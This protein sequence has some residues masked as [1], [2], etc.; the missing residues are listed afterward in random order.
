MEDE[1]IAN[2][3]RFVEGIIANDIA[4][5][6]GGSAKSIGVF[7]LAGE[8]GTLDIGAVGHFQNVGHVGGCGDIENG[9]L[10]AIFD[11]VDDTANEN[12]SARGNCFAG[13]EEDFELWVAGPGFLDEANEAGD[14]VVVR[15]DE[16]ASA[17]VEP[18][19]LAEVFVE[20][21]KDVFKGTLEGVGSLLA[22]GVKVETLDSLKVVFIH[23][24]SQDA[25]AGSGSAWVVNFGAGF[26]VF[27]I[28]AQAG[29]NPTVSTEDLFAVVL[30]LGEGIKD[31][32]VGHFD[33]FTHL[34]RFVSGR[35]Y[36]NFATEVLGSEACFE[37]SAGGGAGEVI[38]KDGIDRGAREGLLSE[39]DFGAGFVLDVFQDASVVVEG[40]LVENVGRCGKTA[41]AEG[42]G[43]LWNGGG[44]FAAGWNG[45]FHDKGARC[46][47]SWIHFGI[48]N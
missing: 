5:E 31:D 27:G 7:F 39:K 45:S 24:A 34:V 11:D 9:D 8:A 32:V 2:L 4:T 17:H 21:G 22:E 28:D 25:E 12:S 1:L 16:V 40:A 33:K 42:I 44:S 46:A 14:I 13:L 15:G 6:A 26:G 35:K 36:V 37:E 20:F 38:S 3:E 10:H 41:L 18:F 29:G 19:H 48:K 30:P 23:D 47:G 43:N